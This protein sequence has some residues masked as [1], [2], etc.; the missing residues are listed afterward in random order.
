MSLVRL[1]MATKLSTIYTT[2]NDAVIEVNREVGFKLARVLQVVRGRVG[3]ASEEIEYVG[4]GLCS[5]EAQQASSAPL[6]LIWEIYC[7]LP[8]NLLR[9]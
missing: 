1:D 3:L 6:K 8:S 5:D 4:L 7:T 9:G 2:T